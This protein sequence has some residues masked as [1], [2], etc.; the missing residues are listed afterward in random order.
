MGSCFGYITER[1]NMR[2]RKTSDYSPC[3]KGSKEEQAAINA[4]REMM[5]TFESRGQVE[6]EKSKWARK[7]EKATGKS[8]H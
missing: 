3:M 8:F 1:I 4:R 5:K 6:H 2:T 7:M